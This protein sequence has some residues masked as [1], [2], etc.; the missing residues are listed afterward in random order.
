MKLIEHTYAIKNLLSHGPSSED[1]SYSNRLIAH[2][3]QAARSRLIRQKIDKY[4]FLSEQSYQNLCVPLELDNI[5]DCCDV[6]DM[7]CKVLK[8]S[9]IIPKFLTSR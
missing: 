1:H 5:H 4:N 8:S 9:I 3:L 7:D 6:P 2:F